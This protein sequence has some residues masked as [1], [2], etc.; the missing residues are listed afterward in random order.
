VIKVGGKQGGGGNCLN[1]EAQKY[2][3][4]QKSK[5]FRLLL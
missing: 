1:T 4:P 2:Q 5:N 3:N